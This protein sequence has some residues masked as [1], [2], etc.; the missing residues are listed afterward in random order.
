MQMGDHAFYAIAL[1][2]IGAD[3]GVQGRGGSAA[4]RRCSAQLAGMSTNRERPKPRG[5]VPSTAA[6]TISGAKKASDK[7]IRA[8]RSFSPA[9]SAMAS[10]PATLPETISSSHRRAR[11][12]PDTSRILASDRIGRGSCGPGE[13]GAITSRLRMKV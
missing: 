10:M 4:A 3:R 12:M 6:L 13:V 1:E 2:V 11:A 5:N 9:R 7:V 8:D